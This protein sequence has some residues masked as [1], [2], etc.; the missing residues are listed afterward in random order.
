MNLLLIG[1]GKM[2]K[3]IEK[4]THDRHHDIIHIIDEKNH[5]DLK[6][7]PATSIDMAIEFTTPESAYNNIRTCLERNIPV[8]SGTTGWLDKKPEL[9][10]LCETKKGAFFYAS[11]FSLG[12]NMFFK[13]ADH[14]GDLMRIK[15]YSIEISETHHTGKKDIPSGTAISL[16]ERLLAKSSR[17]KAWTVS[18]DPQENTI[19]IRSFR[20]K[21][22]PGDHE[23]VFTSEDDDISI[24]HRAVSR[25][26]FA[27]GAILAAEW[28]VGKKGT[29]G[30]EDLLSI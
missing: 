5:A 4:I 11:N 10:A 29:F 22:V 13:I 7:L 16:A 24:R 2:G 26:G 8:V 25:K 18:T 30:M 12:V 9:D 19:P 15:D 20:Q 6:T 21:D 17:Y 1:Y 3:T 28:L 14:M 27:E 23:V